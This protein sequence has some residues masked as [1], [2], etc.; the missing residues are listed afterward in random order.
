[1]IIAAAVVIALGV[2]AGSVSGSALRAEPRWL[3]GT[4][5]S[6]AAGPVLAPLNEDAPAPSRDAL[7]ARIGGLLHDN[8]L[9]KHV[10]ASVVDVVTGESI[11]DDGG[12]APAVPAST[13]KLATGAAVLVSR[14]PDYRI[15]TRAVAGSE[16]GEVVLIGG[17]DP[18]LAAG[19]K[20]AYPGA[21]RLDKLAAQVKKALGGTK[22]T[23]VTV[24]ASLFE[25]STMGPG[26]FAVDMKGGFIA[27]ITSLMTDGARREP[28]PAAQAARYDNPALAAGQLFAKAL[29]L[30]P[31]T[32]TVTSHATD[33]E[34]KK[35]GEVLSP[36]MAS[37]VERMLL[38]SDN[39][40][41]EALAR[42]VALA[43]GLPASFAGGAQ[44]TRDALEEIGVPTAGFGLVDGSG[45]SDRNHLSAELLT[46]IV[47]HAAS[48][49]E[50]K[51]R[52]IISGLPVAAYSGTLTNRYVSSSSGKSAAGV[53]RA[54]TGT[55]TGV[56]ALAGLAV[57][58]DGRLLAFSIMADQ[59]S[60]SYLGQFALDKVA[61]A[62]AACGCS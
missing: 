55:L 37:L 26:W 40:V 57:D 52:A 38:T 60:D 62:I 20:M 59:A 28:K 34:A 19:A 48:D 15:P 13:T 9:G 46:S 45:L 22:P 30:S 10:T 51:L 41:A 12:G 4:L 44:A 14:G 53:V 47:S 39:V 61:A 16:P 21:A 25:G 27:N 36:T 42:Q 8:R 18:T 11:F 54:K 6:G 31:S 24:D 17:G 7:A 23:K 50:P 1:M 58:A 43:R 33:P 32:V 49:D 35:L 2:V 56:T 5:G 3:A 29:G